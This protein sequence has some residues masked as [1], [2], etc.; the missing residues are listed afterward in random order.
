MIRLLLMTAAL[1]MAQ[2]ETPPDVIQFLRELGTDLANAHAD[3]VN[4]PYANPRQFL[5]HFDPAMPGFTKLREYVEDLTARVGVGSVIEVASESG[6]ERKREMQ[7]DWVLEIL[8]K[9]LIQDKSPRR[10]LIKCTIEKKGKKWKFVAFE[11]VEFF[12]Y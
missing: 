11:P 5:D 1:A 3:P 12:K 6:D 8:D 7:L 4:Q 2:D 9:T 10:E